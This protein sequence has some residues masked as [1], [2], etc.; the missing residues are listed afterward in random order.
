MLPFLV[1]QTLLNSKRRYDWL[2]DYGITTAPA[3]WIPPATAAREGEPS[4]S[5]LRARLADW[6]DLVGFASGVALNLSFY[7]WIFQPSFHRGGLLFRLALT[8]FGILG[9][10]YVKILNRK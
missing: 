5:K 1:E 10:L 9:F 6:A 7:F 4:P 2:G 8:A 3:G